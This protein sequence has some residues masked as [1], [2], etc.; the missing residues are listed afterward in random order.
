M[1][2]RLLLLLLVG[3]ALLVF[4]LTVLNAQE[5][6]EEFTYA[7]ETEIP[8][9]PEGLTWLNVDR[10]LTLEDLQGR[11][12]LFDFWTYGCVNCMHIIP[13]LKQLEAEFG[14]DLLVIGVHSAKFEN[15]GVTE[16]IRQIIQRYGVEHPVVNDVD[17]QIWQTYGVQA[18]PS[19]YVID[20]TGK[21]VGRMS[22]EGIYEPLQ[23]VISTMIEEYGAAGLLEKQPLPL[24]PE[25]AALTATPLSFPGKVLADETGG[26]LFIADTE[27]N[28]I[29]VASLEDYSIQDVIGS[30]EEGLS[31]G[32]YADAQF[33]SPQGMSLVDNIL[34]VAD[35]E[36][37]AIRAV[38]LD[39]KIV[40]RFAGTG[41]NAGFNLIGGDAPDTPMRSP[42]DLAYQ[43]GV[44]YIAMAGSHQIWALTFE[45]M[46]LN[47]FAGSSAEGLID[48]LR[49]N[50]EL[51]QPSGLAIDG[52]NLYFADSESSSIRQVTLGE[53]GRVETL[54]GPIDEPEE[55][56]RLFEFGDIDGERA[57]AR[58]QHPLGVTV[59]EEGQLYIADTYNS[60]IKL[61]DPE[62]MTVE[63]F[64]G[65]TEGGYADGDEALFDEPGGLDYAD[66]KLYVADTNNHVIRVIDIEA[67]SAT[68]VTF[69]NVD[70]LLTE[71]TAALDTTA[72]EALVEGPTAAA[73]GAEQ[74]NILPQTVAPGEGII[75]VDAIM[76]FGYKLNA[77]APFTIEWQPNEFVDVSEPL[78]Q[79]VVPE[80]PIEIPVTFT[81]GQT[82][83]TADMTIYWCE[84]IKET[85][86]FVDRSQIVMPITVSADAVGSA[87][88]VQRELVPPDPAQDNT[89]GQ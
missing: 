5:D 6:D 66:G 56:V 30:G 59:D 86:C 54:I 79:V 3:A 71:G 85:L 72:P 76:P 45:D 46:Q 77:Q 25:A 68:T 33:N 21:F 39:A 31:D 19:L 60:K 48:D 58:L 17:F 15:E 73:F 81:E 10:P 24:A 13:E 35:T 1:R 37:H 75:L 26:R 64:L 84:A 2:N 63:T 42:W 32:A 34:Y 28:R 57:E 82:E 41:S 36:N 11:V 38:D 74:L 9:F 22:G 27:H 61:I 4:G 89:F 88:S 49:D 29:V 16:N 69:P 80:L 55:G 62:A 18:W 12:V 44:L 67:Q 83:V 65:Q 53:E 23:P 52:E 8:E 51:A 50:A 7:G 70:V 40:T 78:Y 43:D 87:I 47:P 14:D 20:P